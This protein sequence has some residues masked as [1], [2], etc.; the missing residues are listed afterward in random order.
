M[1]GGQRGGAEIAGGVEQV[2]ELHPLIA[3]HARDGRRP[4]EVGVD[5]I[6]HYVGAEA[7]L[8]IEHVMRDAD[9]VGDPARIVD[10]LAGATRPG[11]SRGRPVVVELQRHADHRSEEHTSELQSLMRISYAVFCLKTKNINSNY[12]NTLN[13]T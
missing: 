9:P 11:P 7:V 13:N 1:A 12:A 8:V 6:V 5:E 2:A 4:G 10:V 3:A